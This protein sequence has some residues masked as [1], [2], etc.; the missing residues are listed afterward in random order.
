MRFE[1]IP[2]GDVFRQCGNGR[3]LLVD[4][5]RREEYMSGHIPGAICIPYEELRQ[6]IPSL[7]EWEAECRKR[8]GNA[9]IIVYCDR[10]NTSL[11]AARDLYNQGFYVKNVYGGISAYLGPRVREKK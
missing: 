10:G 4:L 7:R 6:N 1:N 9:A 8:Y 3:G 5:R 2:P 11:R